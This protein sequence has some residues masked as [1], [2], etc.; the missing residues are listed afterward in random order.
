MMALVC[1]STCLTACA[2]CLGGWTVRELGE[3]VAGFSRHKKRSG[4][5]LVAV[6]G[7]QRRAEF[8]GLVVETLSPGL[9]SPRERFVDALTRCSMATRSPVLI[10]RNRASSMKP[11]RITICSRIRKPDAEL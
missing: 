4:P 3:P 10:L 1:R 2:G 11:V 9:L 8:H 6:L 7:D 5:E